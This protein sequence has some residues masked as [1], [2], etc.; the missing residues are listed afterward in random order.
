MPYESP[1]GG[2]KV[3]GKA[4]VGGSFTDRV[5]GRQGG[6]KGGRKGGGKGGREEGRVGITLGSI[7]LRL[8]WTL[9]CASV[10]ICH[11]G[12]ISVNTKPNCVF[13]VI[14]ACL[15]TCL[16][17]NCVF[18]HMLCTPDCV[19]NDV[20]SLHTQSGVCNTHVYPVLRVRVDL[21]GG[22]AC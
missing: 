17:T 21:Q 8:Y 22:E 6:R 1:G 11:P 3:L 10:L 18:N 4:E 13:D 12:Q 15:I 9:F 2:T 7:S 5:G 14:F 19:R 16:I 20:M